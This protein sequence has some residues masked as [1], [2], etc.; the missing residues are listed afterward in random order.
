VHTEPALAKA[1]LDC[2]CFEGGEGGG[3][4]KLIVESNIK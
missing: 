1:G 4:V 2:V 3:S